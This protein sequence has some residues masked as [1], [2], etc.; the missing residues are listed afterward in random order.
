MHRYAHGNVHV[1]CTQRQYSLSGLSPFWFASE[2][3]PA[4]PFGQREL[5]ARPLTIEKGTLRAHSFQGEARSCGRVHRSP[6]PPLSKRLAKVPMPLPAFTGPS[7]RNSDLRVLASRHVCRS[8]GK[9]GRTNGLK[10]PAYR[11]TFSLRG[12]S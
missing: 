7:C 2:C 10:A 11:L 12:A 9:S 8:D 6:L 4:M 1:I 3:A 5:Y